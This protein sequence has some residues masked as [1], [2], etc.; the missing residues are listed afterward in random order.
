MCGEKDLPGRSTIDV[1][2]FIGDVNGI[3]ENLQVIPEA[4]TRTNI[5]LIVP[6]NI[7]RRNTTY[8]GL[9]C[10]REELVSPVIGNTNR[11]AVLLVKAD[12]IG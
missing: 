11:K 6:I 8:V 12:Q 3:K 5:N 4:I 7:R 10:A 1:G 2:R 9:P